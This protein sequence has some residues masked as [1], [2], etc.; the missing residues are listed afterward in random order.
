MIFLL[1]YVIIVFVLI[2]SWLEKCRISA[3]GINCC[4][5]WSD[6][7]ASLINSCSDVWCVKILYF[8][9]CHVLG[10]SKFVVVKKIHKIKHFNCTAQYY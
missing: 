9:A 5:L 8:Q 6:I 4:F 10:P 7:W 1:K 2:V 3:L